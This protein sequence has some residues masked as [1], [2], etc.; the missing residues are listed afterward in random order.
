MRSDSLTEAQKRYSKKLIQ[1]NI[2]YQIHELDTGKALQD[3]LKATNQTAN[4]YIKKLIETDLKTK[5]IL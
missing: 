1:F 5:G 3:Y 2:K 4:I